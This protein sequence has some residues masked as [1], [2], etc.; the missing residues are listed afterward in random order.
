VALFFPVLRMVGLVAWTSAFAVPGPD[1]LTCETC[2]ADSMSQKNNNPSRQSWHRSMSLCLVMT[3][4]L[5]L[6]AH[7]LDF[8]PVQTV[9]PS[10]QQ[11]TPDEERRLGHAVSIDGDWM[12]VG[13]PN[14]SFFTAGWEQGKVNVYR[15]Q[16]DTW[17]SAQA[18]IIPLQD[19]EGARCGSSVAIRGDVLLISCTGQSQGKL[20]AYHRHPSNGLFAEGATLLTWWGE[21]TC[22]ESLAM[23]SHGDGPD[24]VRWVAVGCP[25]TTSGG[26]ATGGQV[27]VFR[28]QSGSD[29]WDFITTLSHGFDNPFASWRY[30]H[31]VAIDRIPT[32]Q[33]RVA[34]GMPG[35]QNG[36]GRAF[37]HERNLEGDWD[38]LG[39][40]VR[41][42]SETAQQAGD[43][44]GH[45]VAVSGDHW[46]VG[47]PSA[48]RTSSSL[49][50]R[51]GR[52]H[53]Y[54]TVLLGWSSTGQYL[55]AGHNGAR[56]GQTVVLQQEEL[57]VGAPQF[58]PPDGVSG[59]VYRLERT[60]NGSAHPFESPVYSLRQFLLPDFSSA[61][62][63]HDGQFGYSIAVDPVSH[64]AV[65]GYP[66][67]GFNP[68]A[69]SAVR[70]GQAI[71][72]GIVDSI[73][74]D[75]YMN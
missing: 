44:F 51:T 52:V 75:R 43:H 6:S 26:V 42:L 63:L 32:G 21:A 2:G 22:G 61:F 17:D 48:A 36:R 11:T 34:V 33:I 15:R 74:A 10:G 54:R 16:G 35:Y 64:H 71:I 23:V 60:S 37:L 55:W 53:L 27:Y 46:A 30:G 1:K 8:L 59:A 20:V 68:I 65:I 66:R 45:S 14:H 41:A 31:S 7:A 56:F 9:N 50:I 24:V 62:E 58:E 73:F 12:A 28:G 49:T 40:T 39:P 4:G 67:R 47:A 5:T 72:Y 19:E 25:T 13:S 69:G 70:P 38:L 18:S 29:F 57:W 3:F